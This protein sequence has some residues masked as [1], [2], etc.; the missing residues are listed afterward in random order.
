[1]ITPTALS[2]QGSLPVYK[3]L[4]GDGQEYKGGIGFGPKTFMNFMVWQGERSWQ[5]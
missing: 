3:A 2:C 4:V 5:H 1:M